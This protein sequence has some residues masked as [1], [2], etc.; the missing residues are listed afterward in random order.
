MG[1]ITQNIL[2]NPIGGIRTESNCLDEVLI[3]SDIVL[4]LVEG[5]SDFV[6]DD[7]VLWVDFVGL[8][9]AE[10]R[11]L[12]VVGS[13]VLHADVEVREVAAWEESLTAPVDAHC[14]VKN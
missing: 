14:L 9:E 6:E 8:L 13:E 12:Q 4:F 7:G 5:D 2:Q 11:G 1:Q 3:R 10:H